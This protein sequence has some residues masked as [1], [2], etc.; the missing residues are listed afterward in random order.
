[1]FEHLA[2]NALLQDFTLIGGTALALQIGHRQSVDID[3]WLPALRLDKCVIS[4]I[5]H[6][7][8]AAGFAAELV[9]PHQQMTTGKINGFDLLE[10]AQDYVIGDVKTTFFARADVPYR[11]FDTLPRLANTGA[12]FRIMGEE[13]LFALKSHVIQRRVRSRDLFDLKTFMTRG[14]TLDDIL[15]V[16]RAADP[17]CSPEYT[18]SVLVGDVPLDKDDE[19]FES[20]GV[21]D[22]IQDIY[23]FFKCAVDDYEQAIAEKLFVDKPK[24]ERSE[25]QRQ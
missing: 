4:E 7:A 3:L 24:G 5:V 21:T 22:S 12:S 10:Y 13:G 15:N 17:A 1:V 8:Q 25:P 23:A 20:V 9:T 16:A 11:Y 14:K 6:E 2:G 19:G 18:K